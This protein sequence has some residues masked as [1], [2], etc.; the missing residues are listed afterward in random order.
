NLWHI[1]TMRISVKHAFER[2]LGL[3]PAGFDKDGILYC[4]TR[5]GDY[6]CR[7][8][9]GKWDPLQDPCPGWMLLSYKKKTAASSAITGCPP[10]K[11][12]NENIRDYWAAAGSKGEWLLVDLEGQPDICAL[13]INF[14]EHQARAYTRK[15]KHLYHQY[16]IEGSYDKK[17]WQMV[18][19]KKNNKNDSPHDY[20]EFNSPVCYR[21]LRITALHIPA[22]DVFALSGLR[23]FGKGKGAPPQAIQTYKSRRLSP[24]AV[25]L[26]WQPVSNADGY[27]ILW[28][29]APD[30]LYLSW[31]VY[32]QNSLD[33]TALNKNQPCFIRIDSFNANGFT[34]GKIHKLR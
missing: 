29:I 9:A 20:I 10:A 17:T 18:I 34:P 1:S 27:N 28:G 11:A 21:Y 30:K 23:I 26:Q 32:E 13:Q 6:P 15:S 25:S 5:W 22:E 31:L 7:L 12:V 16:F 19:D 33:L 14:N 24:T 4:N 3:F 8:P 2:R